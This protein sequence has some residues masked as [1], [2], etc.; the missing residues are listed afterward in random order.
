MDEN[1]KRKLYPDLL[2]ECMK[3]H[4]ELSRSGKLHTALP[5]LESFTQDRQKI[6]QSFMQEF[7]KAHDNLRKAG[8]SCE[9]ITPLYSTPQELF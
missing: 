1:E 5:P 6:S 9:A 8:D 3:A 2:K 4:E 7:L